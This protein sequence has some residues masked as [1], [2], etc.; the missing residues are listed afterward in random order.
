MITR[1]PLETV[2]LCWNFVTRSDPMFTGKSVREYVEAIASTSFPSPKGGS[3]LAVAGAMGAAL[4]QMCCQV[5]AKRK[6]Q[7]APRCQEIQ[8]RAEALMGKLLALADRDTEVVED[9]IRALREAKG[10]TA[11]QC[12]NLQESYEAAAQSLEEIKN[13]LVE[14]TELADAMEPVCATSCAIDLVIVRHLVR[15]AMEATAESVLDNGLM[16]QKSGCPL[17]GQS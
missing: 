1:E 17:P 11:E 14:L 10:K 4:L 6:P 15:A 16:P 8:G 3:V 12:R 5:S 7:E 2:H 13:S 9:M